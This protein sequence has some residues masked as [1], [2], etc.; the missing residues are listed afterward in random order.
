MRSLLR[1]KHLYNH[2]D[3]LH[4]VQQGQ[5]SEVTVMCSLTAHWL[6]CPHWE[7][8]GCLL[9]QRQ[10]LSASVPH[11]PPCQRC[12][13]ILS[14]LGTGQTDRG[15]RGCK[16]QAVAHSMATGSSLQHQTMLKLPCAHRCQHWATGS[17][18]ALGVS[19][20]ESVLARAAP[21]FLRQAV[22][23]RLGLCTLAVI[24]TALVSS[25]PFGKAGRV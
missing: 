18:M 24:H 16:S 17:G 19:L 12:A 21:A 6:H 5:L 23:P 22:C 8:K 1:H 2:Q 10:V 13:C 25:G 14:N 7:S 15:T 20:R 9:P 4:V 11:R 3:R